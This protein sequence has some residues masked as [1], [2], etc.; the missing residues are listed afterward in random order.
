MTARYAYY[1]ALWRHASVSKIQTQRHVA[2]EM[3]LYPKKVERGR[4]GWTEQG[5]GVCRFD[6]SL[7]S[8]ARRRWNDK[9]RG[10]EK[11][12]EKEEEEEEGEK[13]GCRA[14]KIKISRLVFQNF[15]ESPTSRFLD[16]V[17]RSR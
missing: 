10:N 5:V 14:N 2:E 6:Y 7:R 11:E 12:E 15:E 16:L 17:S 13:E 3:S 1:A 9:E 8:F 4:V